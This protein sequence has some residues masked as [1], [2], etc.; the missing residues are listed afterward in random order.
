MSKWAYQTDWGIVELP[1]DLAALAESARK[2]KNGRIDR[3]SKTSK[4]MAKFEQEIDRK[5]R[6]GEQP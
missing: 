4:L 3:R 2:T 6:A 5:F 1:A